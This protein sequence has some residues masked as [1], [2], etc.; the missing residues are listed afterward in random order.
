MSGMHLLSANS[1][2]FKRANN[3][4]FSKGRRCG[5]SNQDLVAR[6]W[7]FFYIGKYRNPRD[8]SVLSY[9]T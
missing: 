4:R 3:R 1:G 6:R 9:G 5:V 8:S 2:R 7:V